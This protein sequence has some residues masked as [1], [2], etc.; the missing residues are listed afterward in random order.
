LVAAALGAVYLIVVPSLES[1]LIDAKLSQLRRDAPLAARSLPADRVLWPDFV[2]GTA[3]RTNARVVVYD[4]LHEAPATLTGAQDSHRGPGPAVQGD[5]LAERAA[6]RLRTENGTVSRDD[7]RF[8]E[9]AVPLGLHGP[10]LLLSASLRD[11][12]ANVQLL[13]R[14]LL[15]AGAIALGV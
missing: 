10:I 7:D 2:E 13:Q 9:V 3:T 4:L 6:D 8:A 15:I 1:R 11:S 12:L 5:P 14:R